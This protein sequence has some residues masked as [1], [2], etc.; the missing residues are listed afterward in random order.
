[1]T[2]VLGSLAA[3]T[4]DS[5]A[6]GQGQAPASSDGSVA[7][8]EQGQQLN[9]AAAAGLEKTLQA[10][11]DD[12]NAHEQLVGYYYVTAVIVPSNAQ[13]RPDPN[14]PTL[15]RDRHLIWLIQHSPGLELL[16]ISPMGVVQPVP[17]AAGY[18]AAM[19]AW[20]H[21]AGQQAAA[22]VNGNAGIFFAQTDDPRAVD[23]LGAA[24][25]GDSQNATWPGAL[26]ELYAHQA[27]SSPAGS[28]ALAQTAA[29]AVRELEKAWNLSGSSNTDP[30]LSRIAKLA[31]V[32]GEDPKAV[33]YATVL[34]NT[35]KP[36]GGQSPL[37]VGGPIH[38]G[39]MVLGQV[40]LHRGDRAGAEQ[41]LLKAGATPGSPQM[42]RFG[43]NFSLARDLL[44]AGSRDV[45]IRYCD[46]VA[47]FWGDGKLATW[48]A[49]IAAGRTPDFGDNLWN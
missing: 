22:H 1:V 17:D 41:Y 5:S 10:T 7:A 43:P 15:A 11:P 36:G 47:K 28:P 32:A 8:A 4:A 14:A 29:S 25:A 48:R 16:G 20:S 35:F 46:E 42:Q 19:D 40:A 49:A 21:Q 27:R 23:L 13:T 6:Q 24:E 12:L 33:Q 9:Q 18:A 30:L 34:L 31:V 37:T 45:V 38:D 39:N 2:L 3:C 44:A 26:G